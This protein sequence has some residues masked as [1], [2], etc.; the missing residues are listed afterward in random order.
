MK[1]FLAEVIHIWDSKK[2]F[3]AR[4]T[5]PAEIST[6]KFLQIGDF[7]LKSVLL[8][9]GDLT[10][11]LLRQNQATMHEMTLND[12]TV[13]VYFTNPPS[14]RIHEYPSEK[15]F[16]HGIFSGSTKNSWWCLR[17][18]VLNIKMLLSIFWTKRDCLRR[19][20]WLRFW[21][22]IFSWPLLR[23]FPT[24]YK[25]AASHTFLQT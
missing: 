6:Q 2:Y 23:G 1:N 14:D 20:R 15:I 3:R 25:S 5:P 19:T 17:T 8:V 21:V 22:S 10:G 11:Y 4:R 16:S 13:G 7:D 9:V 18:P 24:P 12:L